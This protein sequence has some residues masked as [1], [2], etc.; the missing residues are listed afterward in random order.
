[1]YRYG[2]IFFLIVM[3]YL[4]FFGGVLAAPLSPQGTPCPGAPEDCE[5]FL[6][7][8]VFFPVIVEGAVSTPA[9]TPVITVTPRLPAPGIT[10]RAPM[11]FNGENAERQ[12]YMA[13]VQIID[14]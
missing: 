7:Q 9:A 6:V 14:R 10:P 1:M 4:L 8:Q 5:M 3:I 2:P 11:I 12:N 13:K